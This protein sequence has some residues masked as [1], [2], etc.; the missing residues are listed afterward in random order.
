MRAEAALQR[1]LELNPDLPLAHNL[2]GATRHRC[3]PCAR[4]DGEAARPGQSP[5]HRSGAVRRAGLR[6][7]ILRVARRLA[8]G[9]C[10]GAPPRS[11]DQD[12]GDSHAVDAARTRGRACQY[13]GGA[14]GRRLLVRR[15]G[16]RKE[17]LAFLA[18]KEK[19]APARIQQIIG[20]LRALL[21]GRRAD[22][23]AGDSRDRRVRLPRS[24][25]PVLPGR[26]SW[27]TRGPSM[28]PSRCWNAP[29]RR[30][31]AVI[32]YSRPTSGSIPYVI[33]RRLPPCSAAHEREHELAA[34]AFDAAGG[35]RVLGAG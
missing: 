3:G 29:A 4:G 13:G 31:S 18:E 21:E 8:P 24:R 27:P 23:I 5:E 34:A 22:A 1:A 16:P 11:D 14:G 7:P 12:L 35:D 17:A 6:L 15:T 2:T 33:D 10:T 9:G 20:A 26:A 30:G 28:T 25:R 19:S 32:R